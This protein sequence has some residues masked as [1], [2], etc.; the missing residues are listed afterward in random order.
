MHFFMLCHHCKIPSLFEVSLLLNWS[1]YLTCVRTLLSYLLWLYNKCQWARPPPLSNF[2][3]SISRPFFPFCPSKYILK[4]WKILLKFLSGSIVDHFEKIWH[5][6]L[7]WM[8]VGS[9]VGGG[10][11]VPSFEGH[12]IIFFQ[13]IL[14]NSNFIVS[15]FLYFFIIGWG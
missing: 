4:L 10:V 2:F 5:Q 8:E 11:F 7:H 3:L 14:S 6:I 9:W 1:I 12:I 13:V 15:L